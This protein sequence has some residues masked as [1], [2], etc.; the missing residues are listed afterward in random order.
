MA[1]KMD[2]DRHGPVDKGFS[3]LPSNISGSQSYDFNQSWT[4]TVHQTTECDGINEG[5]AY[6]AGSPVVETSVVLD[7]LVVYQKDLVLF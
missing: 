3:P 5:P 1:T 7:V 4:T 2:A 6:A